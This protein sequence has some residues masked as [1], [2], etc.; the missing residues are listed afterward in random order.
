M[1]KMRFLNI[2]FC[3]R[4][5]SSHSYKSRLKELNA[6]TSGKPVCGCKFGSFPGH[7]GCTCMYLSLG[8]IS[9]CPHPLIYKALCLCANYS[10]GWGTLSMTECS[11]SQTVSTPGLLET[12]TETVWSDVHLIKREVASPECTYSNKACSLR[13][14]PTPSIWQRDTLLYLITE[15]CCWWLC[16]GV[17]GCWRYG[18]LG[19]RK[20]L[21]NEALSS[22]RPLSRSLSAA[23]LLAESSRKDCISGLIY[24]QLLTFMC[25]FIYNLYFFHRAPT[26]GFQ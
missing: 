10:A 4:P 6:V 5:K 23:H 1:L 9:I 7:P 2:I 17:C 3:I 21:M 24:D 14:P 18:T 16:L 12:Q 25:S 13:S 20:C 22:A 8:Q 11:V 15:S 26:C 19:Y